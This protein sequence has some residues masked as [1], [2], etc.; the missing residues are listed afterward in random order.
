MSLTW[1]D[2]FLNNHKKNFLRSLFVSLSTSEKE[3]LD[4]IFNDRKLSKELDREESD[5]E[6]NEEEFDKELNKEK[7]DREC[8]I[9]KSDEEEFDLSKSRT[10]SNNIDIKLLNKAVEKK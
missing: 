3:L 1:Q 9:K 2:H 6:L 10:L 8:I 4:L 7:F 5:R